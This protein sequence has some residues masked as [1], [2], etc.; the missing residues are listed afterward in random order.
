MKKQE[1]APLPEIPE[2][3]VIKVLKEKGIEDTDSVILLNEWTEQEEVKAGTDPMGHITLERKRGRL[4]LAAGFVTEAVE[5]L[6]QAAYQARQNKDTGLYD[7][8][9]DE[10]DG[11]E[12]LADN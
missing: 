4:Y 11:V 3:I 5:S 7:L 8:I 12:M 10:I 9:W 1:K 2:S 6:K